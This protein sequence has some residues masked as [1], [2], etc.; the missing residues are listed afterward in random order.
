LKMPIMAI[1]G[2]TD[3]YIKP[4]E[5]NGFKKTKADATLLVIPNMNHVLKDAPADKEKNLATYN[6]PELP[7]KPEL[8]TG[9]VDFINK[10][11]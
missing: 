7:I 1:Q 10:L 4:D 5:V 6:Q 11:K 3:L 9:V 8:V 2:S